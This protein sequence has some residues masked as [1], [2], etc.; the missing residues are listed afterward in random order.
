M[1]LIPQPTVC[2]AFLKTKSDV[3]HFPHQPTNPRSVSL[4]RH[5]ERGFCDA[6]ISISRCPPRGKLDAL[7]GNM[8]D[9]SNL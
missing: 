3:T 7:I 8:M 1:S 6:C 4:K 9:Y 5:D 2:I